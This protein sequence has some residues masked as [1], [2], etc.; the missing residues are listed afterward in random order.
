MFVLQHRFS[1]SLFDSI[2]VHTTYSN[3]KRTPVAGGNHELT[4]FI[5]TRIINVI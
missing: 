2:P 3:N 1:R 4:V 5:T